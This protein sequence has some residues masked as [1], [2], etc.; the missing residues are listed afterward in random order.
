MD[1]TQQLQ[2]PVLLQRRM[3]TTD[4]VHLGDANP[5]RFAN[6]TDN[7]VDR[8]FEGMRIPFFG[9]E[10]TELAREDTNVG[11]IYVTVVDVGRDVAVPLLPGRARHYSQRVK[12][13]G[14]IEL[15]SFDIRDALPVLYLLGDRLKVDWNER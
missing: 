11:A 15:Q 14:A 3:Q 5:E 12:I 13:V 6:H 1:P 10:C 8:V 4:H 7:L 2:I 9:R